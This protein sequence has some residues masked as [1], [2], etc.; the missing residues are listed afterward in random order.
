MQ[1]DALQNNKNRCKIKKNTVSCIFENKNIYLCKIHIEVLNRNNLKLYEN[2]EIKKLEKLIK[3]I[4]IYNCINCETKW[5]I[6][7]IPPHNFNKYEISC[8]ICKHYQCCNEKIKEL[9]IFYKHLLNVAPYTRFDKKMPPAW[10][11]WMRCRIK[12]YLINNKI[13]DNDNFIHDLI[14]TI[15]DYVQWLKLFND[16][17]KYKKSIKRSNLLL[18]Y[19]KNNENTIRKY[20]EKESH[21]FPD[22]NLRYNNDV[23]KEDWN[24]IFLKE[25]IENMKLMKS[26]GFDAD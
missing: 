23:I 19:I 11:G 16:R 14:Y 8:P 18:K 2:K 25:G 21:L 24:D 17:N 7:D 10:H 20:I 26:D 5:A 3:K 15:E 22:V 4:D 12:P 1:C 9:S 13:I 6:Y